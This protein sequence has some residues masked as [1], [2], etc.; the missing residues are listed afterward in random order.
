[1]ATGF[2]TMTVIDTHCRSPG[3]CLLERH[4]WGWDDRIQH[5]PCSPGTETLVM[6]Q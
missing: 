3:S 4:A 1:M 5:R 6:L 2:L